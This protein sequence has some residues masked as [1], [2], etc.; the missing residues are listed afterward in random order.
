MQDLIKIV[1]LH[2]KRYRLFEDNCFWEP[3]CIC[4][5]P[6]DKKILVSQ[7]QSKY[8]KIILKAVFLPLKTKIMKDKIPGISKCNLLFLGC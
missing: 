6:G 8:Q 5:L 1:S 7:I 3:K 4:S 2:H